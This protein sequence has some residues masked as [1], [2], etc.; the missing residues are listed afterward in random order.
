VIKIGS[1]QCFENQFYDERFVNY[2]DG[3]DQ[4]AMQ[5]G[6]GVIVVG[7]VNEFDFVVTFVF[8]FKKIGLKRLFC[9]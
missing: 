1:Q 9:F 3:I 6:I 2:G 7:V 4:K 5:M 8:I